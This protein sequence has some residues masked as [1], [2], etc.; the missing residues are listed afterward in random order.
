MHRYTLSAAIVLLASAL[1]ATSPAGT[2]RVILGSAKNDVLKGTQRADTLDGRGGNDRLS[3][4]GGN[5]V[6]V[7]GKGNDTLVGGVGKDK[8][9][10]GAG[11]DTAVADTGDTVGTDCEVVK[12]LPAPPVVEPPPSPPPAPGPKALPGKYCGFTNQGKSI[13]IDVTSDG[14]AVN[15]FDTTSD[16]N[17]GEFEAT[18][19]LSFGGTSLIQPDLSFAFK[20]EGPIDSGDP[21]VTNILANYTVTGRF[22][23][24]GNAT[25]T[26]LLSKFTFDYEG[27]HFDCSAAPYAWQARRGA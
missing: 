24:A 5:D 26:L 4:L 18:F 8:L 6:L 10:C 21:A 3:G 1:V 17:C 23:T 12:G 7:G 20:Y 13:C 25:G 16:L 9:R 19:S 22:D 14:L 11:K 2:L 27:T 15:Q